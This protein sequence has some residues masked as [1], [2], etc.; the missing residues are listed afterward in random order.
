LM[1][2]LLGEIKVPG[3]EGTDHTLHGWI[4]DNLFL[5]WAAPI[6]ASLAFA[7]SYVL[8]WLFLMWLL[9]RKGI[10]IRV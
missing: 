2:G 3:R 7:L 5:S 10:Y 4:F 8:F 9:Y 6:N 1:S